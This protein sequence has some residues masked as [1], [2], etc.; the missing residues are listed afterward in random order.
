MAQE[1]ASRQHRRFGSTRCDWDRRDESEKRRHGQ[2]KRDASRQSSHRGDRKY[3]VFGPHSLGAQPSRPEG[4]RALAVDW[5]ACYQSLRLGKT[6]LSIPRF[7]RSDYHSGNCIIAESACDCRGF[8]PFGGV[9]PIQGEPGV[10]A[11]QTRYRRVGLDQGHRL[12]SRMI[13][14]R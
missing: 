5:L 7:T 11:K 2:R 8:E 9:S 1:R 3:R 14:H 12:I 10:V 4:F 13:L 6:Y